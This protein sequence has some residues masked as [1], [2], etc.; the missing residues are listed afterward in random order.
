MLTS[1]NRKAVVT[2]DDMETIGIVN[3]RDCLVIQTYNYQCS[4]P[5]NNQGK[6]FGNTNGAIL[7][8]EVIIDSFHLM[9]SFYRMLTSREK[10]TISL[11]FNPLFSQDRSLK[12]YD[13][14]I[15]VEGYVVDIQEDYSTEKDSNGID[16]QMYATICL[17]ISSI[18]YKSDSTTLRNVISR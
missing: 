14:V 8:L 6:P 11:I 10:H 4:R 12:E 2:T 18:T 9:K 7:T 15:N 17:L 1:L 5:L 3:Q 16:K 13:Q